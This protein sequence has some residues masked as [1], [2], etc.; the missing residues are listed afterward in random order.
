MS[1]A[2]AKRYA[3]ALFEIANDDT[4][5]AS[6]NNEFEGMIQVFEEN[7][8]LQ[9]VLNN[10]IVADHVKLS[11]I[12]A[13]FS[14]ASQHLSNLFTVLGTNKRVSLLQDLAKAYVTI[15]EESKK[16]QRATVTTAVSLDAAMEAKVQE[17]VKE[18]TGSQALLTAEVDESIIGGFILRI[19]DMQFDASIAGSLQTVKRKLV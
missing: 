8:D 7:K 18:L 1:R 2:A 13:V 6:L 15:F 3:K 10:P 16:I 5:R 11:V 12:T 19:G 14:S 17:K 4:T 9:L